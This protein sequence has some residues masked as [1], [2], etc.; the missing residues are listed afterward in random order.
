MAPSRMFVP[1]DQEWLSDVSNS[2]VSLS[3]H[4]TCTHSDTLITTPTCCTAVSFQVVHSARFAPFLGTFGALVVCPSRH[5]AD[6]TGQRVLFLSLSLFCVV[7]CLTCLSPQLFVTL[8]WILEERVRR[9][10]TSTGGTATDGTV[11][12]SLLLRR[13]EVLGKV[14]VSYVA[15]W[16][17]AL[18]GFLVS[19]DV[20]S[21]HH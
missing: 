1:Q 21:P 15:L 7:V 20:G 11:G 13:E 3:T 8:N 5:A 16:V 4:G 2:G 9:D 17:L 6:Y 14:V 12:F 10:A 19:F 18:C